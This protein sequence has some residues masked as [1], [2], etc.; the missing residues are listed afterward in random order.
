[1]KSILVPFI[2][3]HHLE[4]FVKLEEQLGLVYKDE[5]YWNEVEQSDDFQLNQK[6]KVQIIEIDPDGERI[7]LS[8]KA[9]QIKIESNL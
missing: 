9:T 7:I 5:L 6:I 8:H 3:L 4:Y 1:M 2:P